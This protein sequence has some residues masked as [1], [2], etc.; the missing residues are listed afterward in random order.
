MKIYYVQI[1]EPQNQADIII[2]V[3]ANSKDEAKEKA[4]KTLYLNHCV[5]C[6]TKEEAIESVAENNIMAIDEDGCEID[7]EEDN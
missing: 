7:L 6:L 5:Y 3:E 1:D 2:K 4:L